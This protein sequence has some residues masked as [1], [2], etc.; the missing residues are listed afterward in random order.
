M[1]ARSVQKLVAQAAA[2]ALNTQTLCTPFLAKRGWK[3]QLDIEDLEKLAVT[4]VPD[5]RRTRLMNRG[6]ARLNELVTEIVVQRQHGGAELTDEQLNERCD[7]VADFAQEVED[8]LASPTNKLAIGE[9][10]DDLVAEPTDVE[11]EF[12]GDVLIEDG[13]MSI[14][15]AITYRILR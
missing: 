3:P 14:R 10:P 11:Q 1:A 4:I 7:L 2:D 15:L 8:F 13:V 12:D 5:F 6:G 9:E